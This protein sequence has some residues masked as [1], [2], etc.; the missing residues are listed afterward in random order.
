MV[1]YNNIL[2]CYIMESNRKLDETTR[3]K[4]GVQENECYKQS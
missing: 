1:A 2:S 3:K 4:E